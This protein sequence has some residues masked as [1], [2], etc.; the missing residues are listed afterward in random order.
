MIRLMKPD[1]SFD[2]VAG[3]IRAFLES[4]ILTRG[5]YLQQFERMVGEY[6]GAEHA[7]A[8]TSAT[9]ALHLALVSAGIETGDEVLVSDFTFPASGNA[10]IQS[11][12]HPVLVDC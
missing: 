11:G 7:F 4:G 9:T 10:I 12:A 5:R 8:T 3:D 2:E 6:V 1:I